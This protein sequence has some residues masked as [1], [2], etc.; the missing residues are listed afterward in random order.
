MTTSIQSFIHRRVIVLPE[1]TPA[2]AAAKAMRDHQVGC[3]LVMNS[4]RRIVGIVTDRDF[5]CRW[6]AEIADSSVPISRLM[7]PEIYKR[8]ENSGLAD[9]IALMEN[10]G[11]RRVPII[12]EDIHH[13]EKAVGIITLDDL[14]AVGAI[15]PHHLS[16]II[17]RQIGRRLSVANRIPPSVRSQRR[18][19]AH[20]HQTMDRLCTYLVKQTGVSDE[21]SPQIIQFLLGCLVMRVSATAGAHFVA[22]LPRLLQEQLA[23]LPPGPDRSISLD[24]IL[25]ELHSR[26]NLPEDLSRHVFHHFLSGLQ[27]LVD[28]G[29]IQHLKAQLPEDFKALFPLE[30]RTMPIPTAATSLTQPSVIPVKPGSVPMTLRSK[31]F[32]YGSEIPRQYTGEGE[33][34]NPSLEWSQPPSDTQ[35]IVIFCED[36]DSTYE[37]SWTHWILYG[38]SPTHCSIP[39]GI[40]KD[41][42]LGVPF[43]LKQ[44]KNSWGNIGYQGPM[45]PIGHPEHRYIFRVLALDRP[46]S[47]PGG[48][49]RAQ[50]ANEIRGHI[51]AEA[52]YLGSYQHA[53]ARKTA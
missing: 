21:I 30:T 38:V 25:A 3:V 41:Q 29:Q 28:W 49:S 8:D 24:W 42:E 26:F 20:L 27:N 44:G 31:S 45:P 1:E 51:L 13:R 40:Q 18:S 52:E 5:A 43:K 48:A 7:T 46:I 22:Q 53:T 12:N 15:A 19:E 23:T 47:L 39:E 11:I 17:R 34:R 2:P 37:T 50:I 35:E 4:D 32:L 10:H 14:I 36:P 9:I 6:A 33:D 16:R